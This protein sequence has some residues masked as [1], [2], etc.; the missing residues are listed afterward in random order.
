MSVL[1][2]GVLIVMVLTL[3]YYYDL[4]SHHRVWLGE[5]DGRS[6]KIEVRQDKCWIDVDGERVLEQ[7][8]ERALRPVVTGGG[9][10]IRYCFKYDLRKKCAALGGQE[11][12]LISDWTHSNRGEV[13]FFLGG[14]RIPLL[15]QSNKEAQEIIKQQQ[16]LKKSSPVITDKRWESAHIILG[17]L[18]HQLG[19]EHHAVLEQLRKQLAEQFLMLEEMEHEHVKNIWKDEADRQERIEAIEAELA[20]TL[21][22]IERLHQLALTGRQQDIQERDMEAVYE[23]IQTLEIDHSLDAPSTSRPKL[24]KAQQAK[25]RDI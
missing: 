15:E 12:S 24:K 25:S 13:S 2:V 1:I 11:L 4:R 16:Q 20:H 6:I 14:T 3:R 8:I 9:G 18:Q 19:E 21:S 7:E 22:L 5:V 10:R 23:L 17:Q